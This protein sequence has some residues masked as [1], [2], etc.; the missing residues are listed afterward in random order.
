MGALSEAVQSFTDIHM[1]PAFPHACQP[2]LAKTYA[3]KLNELHKV[4]K[5]LCPLGSKVRLPSCISK[6]GISKVTLCLCENPT[7][8]AI[9]YASL[10]PIGVNVLKG[11]IFVLFANVMWRK[12]GNR[13]KYV[14]AELFLYMWGLELHL[15]FMMANITSLVEC[16]KRHQTENMPKMECSMWCFCINNLCFARCM[17]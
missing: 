7:Y 11:W 12:F 8:S 16:K 4:L 2:F 17:H 10:W 5:R 3:D 1:P 13:A 9:I 15:L 6:R 14:S